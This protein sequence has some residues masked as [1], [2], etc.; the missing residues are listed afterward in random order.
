MPSTLYAYYIF[1]CCMMYATEIFFTHVFK[2]RVIEFLGWGKGW[3]GMI[4]D[5]EMFE[6]AVA[7]S[8]KPKVLYLPTWVASPISTKLL[9]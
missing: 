1:V 8:C 4:D 5:N 7:V 6:R 2:A 3:E 9:W